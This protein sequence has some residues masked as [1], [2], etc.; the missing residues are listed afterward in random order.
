VKLYADAPFFRSRQILLDAVVALWIVLWVALGFL[1]HDVVAYLAKPAEA[2]SRSTDRLA[3]SFD[4]L[5]DSARGVP[6]VG[7]Q[8][9]EPFRSAADASREVAARGEDQR[10]ATLRVAL[11]LSLLIS[12]GPVIAI[13]LPY[14]LY[15]SRWLREANAALGLRV[16]ADDLYLFALRAV[17]KRP[18][19][20]LRK[21]TRDPA[22]ALAAGDYE[23]LASL[24]LK[25]LGLRP[26]H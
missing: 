9:E 11:V 1:V 4:E 5:G 13:L 6:V 8:L 17:A 24:E 15:R 10:D 26:D 14:V 18:L 2:V 7:D 21:V 3:D 20:E 12:I 23:A 16:D 25:R 19:R 22:A